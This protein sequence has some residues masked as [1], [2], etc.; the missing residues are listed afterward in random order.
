MKT[1]ETL[2]A[3]SR[4]VAALGGESSRCLARKA[5]CR[6]RAVRLARATSLA[7]RARLALV[8]L[9][10]VGRLAFERRL[11]VLGARVRHLGCQIHR[12]VAH[13]RRRKTQRRVSV[14]RAQ[15]TTPMRKWGAE[16]S[17]PARRS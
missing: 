16:W 10:R 2:T 12:R 1:L 11:G 14:R 5:F 9:A 17:A 15:R 6:A 13:L 8:G 4:S 7:W 3:T